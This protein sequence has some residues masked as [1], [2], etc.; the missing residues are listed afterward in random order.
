MSIFKTDLSELNDLDAYIGEYGDKARRAINDVLH[1]D[2]PSAVK[3]NII[4]LIHD[5]GRKWKGKV[6]PA[7]RSQ[8][9][10]EEKGNL[11][12]TIKSKPS[13]GYL[14]FPDD[15]S[16]TR[17]HAGNQQFMKR[18]GDQSINRIVELCIKKIIK[19]E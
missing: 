14:Y 18:G 8:P 15:G 4:P 3:K 2:A 11:S 5:S 17:K 7:S 13:Y 12:L 10:R 6:A 1:D 16:N 9:F 19:E